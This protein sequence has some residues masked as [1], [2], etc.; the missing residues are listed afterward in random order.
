VLIEPR[1]FFDNNSGKFKVEGRVLGERTTREYQDID[2]EIQK[3]EGQVEQGVPG[4]KDKLD[5]YRDKRTEIE[6]KLD[7]AR[8]D[9]SQNTSAV[10]RMTSGYKTPEA[11]YASQLGVTE[12]V[13]MESMKDPAMRKEIIQYFSSNQ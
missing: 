11:Y 9:A 12:D 8:Y 7:I 13:F 4:A 3:L 1:I 10:E 5:G 2:N 6:S